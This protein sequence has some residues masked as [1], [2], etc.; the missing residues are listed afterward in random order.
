MIEAISTW[1]IPVISYKF[2][3]LKEK[4]Y[5]P[6]RTAGW[7]L[8]DIVLLHN[9]QIIYFKI[10]SDIGKPHEIIILFDKYA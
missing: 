3:V 8:S 10:L 7:G 1:T 4:L 5:L 6:R 2:R 9:Y